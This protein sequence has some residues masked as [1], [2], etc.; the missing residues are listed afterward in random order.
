MCLDGTPSHV[1]LLRNLGVVA[2]L[3]QQISDLLLA[4]T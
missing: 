4:R 3:Q 1:K 2:A